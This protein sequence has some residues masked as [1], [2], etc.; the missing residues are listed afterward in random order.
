MQLYV[1][2]CLKFIFMSK[3]FEKKKKWNQQKPIINSD[4]LFDLQEASV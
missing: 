4:E 3:N 2:H 1:W